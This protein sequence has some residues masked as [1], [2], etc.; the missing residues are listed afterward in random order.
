MSTPKLTF[1]KFF[2]AFLLTL[3][4][5]F[6]HA[7][8]DI[9]SSFSNRMNYIFQ[10]LEKNRV[11]NGLLLDYAMEF[12]NLSNFNGSALTDSNKVMTSEFWE[13]YNTLYLS[14]I[15]SNGFTIQNPALFDSLWFS[16]RG[17]GKIVLS[18]LF[19]NY[20]RL[21]DDAAQ[22][23]LVTIQ[24]DQVIDRYVNGVWQNP[25]QAEKLFAI[26]P[27][28]EFYQGKS[29]Q[30]ILPPGLWQTNA[31]GE[32]SNISIDLDDGQGYRSLTVGQPITLNYADTGMK[33]WKYRLQLT[34]GQYLYSHSQ[35]RIIIA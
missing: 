12:T 29:L 18:G 1:R 26:S 7:Q 25:Y 14:R 33:V 32:V 13:I 31:A 4:F 5:N 15:H 3:I 21:R 17:Y 2:Y 9:N 11:P 27:S 28:I 19:Y 24:N 8:T 30:V 23:N 34:G 20:S 22:A 6:S 16:Q 10:Q 35:V